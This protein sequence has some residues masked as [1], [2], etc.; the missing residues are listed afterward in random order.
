[1]MREKSANQFRL[2][3]CAGASRFQW[4]GQ[5]VK[6]TDFNWELFAF[7]SCQNSTI[8][9]HVA[10]EELRYSFDLCKFITLHLGSYENLLY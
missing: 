2:L 5:P 10:T 9:S 8:L 7:I 1:M 4:L 6:F 3:R